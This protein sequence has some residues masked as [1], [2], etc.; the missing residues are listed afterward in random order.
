MPH[1]RTSRRRAAGC[2][3]TRRTAPR[4]LGGHSWRQLGRAHLRAL[5]GSR[6]C[7]FFHVGR[8]HGVAIEEKQLVCLT[9]LLAAHWFPLTLA[10]NKCTVSCLVV[11]AAREWVH[12]G[13]ACAGRSRMDGAIADPRRR[14]PRNK[15]A[16]RQNSHFCDSRA[17]RHSV[18][19]DPGNGAASD[20]ITATSR[21]LREAHGPAG[22]PFAVVN[23]HLRGNAPRYRGLL[24]NDGQSYAWF[25]LANP[26]MAQATTA[27][28]TVVAPDKCMEAS[29]EE[30]FFSE[31]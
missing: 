1:V 31:S 22:Q 11:A 28:D 6:E 20:E 19:V 24:Y 23:P 26:W 4:H 2:L 14:R 29:R 7:G 13:A 18:D 12:V 10:A 25:A 9:R 30:R 27:D 5:A 16:R 17:K 15:T 8:S 3:A 21:S